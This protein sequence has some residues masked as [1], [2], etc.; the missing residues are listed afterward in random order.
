M[1]GAMNDTNL[2]RCDECG[3]NIPE[4][5]WSLHR[6]TCPRL[7]QQQQQHS[8]RRGGRQGTSAAMDQHRHPLEHESHDREATNEPVA[9]V[10]T[11]RCDQCGHAI[12]ETNRVVHEATCRAQHAEEPAIT[13]IV[14]QETPEAVETLL[15]GEDFE[16]AAETHPVEASTAANTDGWTCPRCTL[17]NLSAA[18]RCDACLYENVPTDPLIQQNQSRPEEQ[19]DDAAGVQVDVREVDA[20]TVRAAGTVTTVLSCSL[21]GGLVGGP[22]GAAVGG[23]VGAVMDGVTRFN[24]SRI[25]P[26]QQQHHRP[27][28]VF[29]TMTQTPLGSTMAITNTAPDGRLRTVTIRS[30]AGG[31]N[32]VDRMIRQMLLLN[33]MDQGAVNADQMTYEELLQRFGVG[34]EHRGASQDAINRLPC[35]RLDSA[36]AVDDLKEHTC[37]IC[38]EEFSLGQEMRKLD[39]SHCFHKGCVDRWLATVASCPV[40]KRDISAE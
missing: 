26:Q 20:S 30:P 2:Q 28:M 8:H 1:K 17:Q 7:Q 9:P 34:N 4:T 11:F 36:A 12:P 3:H 40:C 33:A 19:P 21:L 31:P 15:G 29:T 13:N 16:P 14:V 27:R 10:I 39:C 23:V 24:N 25:P 18:R 22:V 38:L 35:T 32:N 37:N 5:N 6:A